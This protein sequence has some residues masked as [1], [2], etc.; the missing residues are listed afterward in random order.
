MLS[1]I[2]NPWFVFALTFLLIWI[3]IFIFVKRSRKEMLWASILTAPLGLT[4]PLFVPEYWNPPS[5]F[6]LAA[7]TGFDIESIIF[8]FAVAGIGAVLYETIFKVEHKK[9]SKHEKHNKRH[10]LHLLIL[11]SPLMVFVIF[12]FS[13]SLN[14]IYI[15]SISMLIGAFATFYCRPDLKKKIFVGGLLFLSLYFISFLIFSAAY[16]EIVEKVWNLNALSGR[17]IFGVPLEEFM[18]AI[19]FGMLWSSYYEHVKWYK[20]EK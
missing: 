4:E 13:T 6:N 3:I 1:R 20:L 15:S 19:T 12:Y 14:P 2:F 7:K 18:F 16:P 8:C 9:V 5:L 17:L 10:K 11:I